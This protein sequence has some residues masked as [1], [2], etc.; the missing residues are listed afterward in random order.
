M[1]PEDEN[2]ARDLY[3]AKA[4]KSHK[5]AFCTALEPIPF[6]KWQGHDKPAIE[7]VW[8][9][10]TTLKIVMVSRFDDAGLTDDLEA[11]L[12][13]SARVPWDSGKIGRLRYTREPVHDHR[14][15]NPHHCQTCDTPL[16]CMI[17]GASLADFD[18]PVCHPESFK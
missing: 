8:P 5:T 13:Y 11:E 9:A 18:C 17:G 12:G 4:A 3:A 7:G 15:F 14:P 16:Q 1:L 10:G 6:S 2:I